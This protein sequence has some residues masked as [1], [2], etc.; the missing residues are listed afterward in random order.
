MN[1]QTEFQIADVR[2]KG[3]FGLSPMAGVGDYAFRT[4]CR[5]HG[6]GYTVTEMVSAKALCYGDRKTEEL[7]FLGKDEHPSAVQIFGAEPP[8]LAE[9][10]QRA[11]EMSGADVLDLNMGCPAG[12][13]VRSGEGSA[14][15][16]D[17][18]R[19]AACIEAV[20]RAVRVPVTVKFRA[21]WDEE[22]RNAVEFAEMAVAAGASALCI[23]GRTR[24]QLY[25]GVADRR[26]M[27]QVVERAGSVPVMVNGDVVSGA[28]GCALLRETGAGFAMIGRGALGNPW[29]FAACQA[30]LAGESFEMPPLPVRL[31]TA[32]RQAVLAAEQKGER[33]ACCEMR[34]HLAHYLRGIRYAARYRERSAHIATL[35]E[36]KTLLDD[37]CEDA[38][39]D[40]A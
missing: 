6:A 12:K 5:E 9:G 31:K 28:S 36:L 32:Y 4:I 40:P 27:Q 13:I 14:L 20:V 35:A 16:R 26:L 25:S 39:T 30:A 11:L 15:M 38:Q 29:I 19:A 37:I 24:A 23:H 7:L 8:F 22:H 3:S 17:L 10:A 2:L 21:G 18:P 1:E 33:T 34:T